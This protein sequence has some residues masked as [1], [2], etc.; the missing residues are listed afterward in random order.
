MIT[1]KKSWQLFHNNFTI[2]KISWILHK[3]LT[4]IWL[5][6]NELLPVLINCSKHFKNHKFTLPMAVYVHQGYQEK[7]SCSCKPIG[8]TSRVYVLGHGGLTHF[9]ECDHC[10][11]QGRDA[12]RCVFTVSFST[13]TNFSNNLGEEK[14]QN[15]VS[16]YTFLFPCK[17]L[18]FMS[19]QH[20][21]FK[22]KW[23][24]WGHMTEF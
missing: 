24:R 14:K 22:E 7:Y 3:I 13:P 20:R 9:N 17:L 16:S 5:I 2:S 1:V 10:I 18:Y 23:W 19:R 11:W 4:F 21:R 8:L 6:L 15:L 12:S